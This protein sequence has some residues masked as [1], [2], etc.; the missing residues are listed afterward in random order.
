MNKEDG[1]KAAFDKW[2]NKHRAKIIQVGL[3]AVLG[4]AHVAANLAMDNLERERNEEN[5]AAIRAEYTEIYKSNGC[6]PELA[7]TYVEQIIK[8]HHQPS[9]KFRHP[10][11]TVGYIRPANKELLGDNNCQ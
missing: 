1:I 10:N 8:E 9:D 5:L 3:I 11:S 2:W 4:G 7:F 6:S